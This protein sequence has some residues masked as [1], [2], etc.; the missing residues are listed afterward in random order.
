[1]SIHQLQVVESNRSRRWVV[2]RGTLAQLNAA[3][4]VELQSYESS[5]GKYHGYAGTANLPTSLAAVVEA[6]NGLD[7]RPIPGKQLGSADPPATGTLTPPHV[8][9]LYN[10]RPERAWVR[11]LA[12][13]IGAAPA[14]ATT[15]AM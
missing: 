4:A 13:M 10:F 12:F 5:H 11:R 2:A 1:L 14:T 6:V 7:N 15:R 8:A 3:F 9:Q